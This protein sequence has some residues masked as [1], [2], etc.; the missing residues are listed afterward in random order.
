MS[1]FQRNGQIKTK[2]TH[3]I[4]VWN[5]KNINLNDKD[6][7]GWTIE[8]LQFVKDKLPNNQIVGLGMWL[9]LDNPFQC[10]STSN[11]CIPWQ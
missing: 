7:I 8:L 10:E 11:S 5:G 6:I 3:I 9:F 2:I 4:K 1:F